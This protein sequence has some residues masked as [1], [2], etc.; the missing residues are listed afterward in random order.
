MPDTVLIGFSYNPGLP[1]SDIYTTFK[2][3]RGLFVT[4]DVGS[5]WSYLRDLDFD[6]GY[7][8]LPKYDTAQSD[9][10]VISASGLM[11]IPSVTTSLEQS[12]M[13]M[14]FFAVYGSTYIRPVFFKT[15]IG[16]RLSEYPED[17][18]MLDLLHSKKFYDFGYTMD[19]Q[20][21]MIFIL[22][23]AVIKNRNPDSI[24]TILRSSSPYIQEILDKANE[25]E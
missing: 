15:I 14:E 1:T 21:N 9:Y 24:A 8:P 16:G 7:A 19:E 6:Q 2:S 11:G 25:M 18:D 13:A 4:W 3:G 10:R 12:G 23:K 22:D 5:C 17:Y 20:E